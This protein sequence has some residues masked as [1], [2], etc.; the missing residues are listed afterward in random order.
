MDRSATTH[1]RLIAAT[2]VLALILAACATAETP[3]GQPGASAAATASATLKASTAPL[4]ATSAAPTPVG[5]PSADPSPTPSPTPKPTPVPSPTPTPAPVQPAGWSLPE[6]VGAARH[7]VDVTAEIDFLGGY[8]VAAECAGAIHYYYAPATGTNR[9]WTARVFALATH[10]EEVGPLIALDGKVVYVA[11]TRYI[12]DGGCGGDRGI[13]VGVYYRS[14][15]LPGGAWS[16]AKRIGA[17]A[18]VLQSFGVDAGMLHA[19]VYGSGGLSFYE[20][21]KG[22]TLHRYRISRLPTGFVAMRIGSDGRARLTYASLGIRY[23]V[24]NGSGFSASRVP[25]TTQVDSDAL[26][27]L[28]AN[29]KGH[30][31]WTRNEQGACGNVPVGTYYATNASGSWKVQRITKETGVSSIEVDKS[32]GRIHV[33]IGGNYFT[34]TTSGSWTRTVLASTTGMASET[35]RF[36]THTGAVLVVYIEGSSGKIKAITSQHCGC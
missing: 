34:K 23:A 12:P 5:T 11:Y 19:V 29:D 4:P 15:T 8:H 9:T 16:P 14:R 30:L 21:L 27:A 35:L 26:V 7:C 20:N 25:G 17:A 2:G 33:L 18:D 28:D 6:G 24:F 22:S 31:V 10:R 36:D 3:S 1:H 32:T 13:P